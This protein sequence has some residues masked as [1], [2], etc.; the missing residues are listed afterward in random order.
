MN[1][2]FSGVVLLKPNGLLVFHH[3][4]VRGFGRRGRIG[5]SAQWVYM[6]N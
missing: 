1:A 2:R 4:F 3:A 5:Y 6:K